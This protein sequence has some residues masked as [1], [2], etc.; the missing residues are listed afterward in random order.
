MEEYSTFGK[1][2]RDFMV[3]NDYIICLN[4]LSDS[5]TV[6]YEKDNRVSLVNEINIERPL[7]VG[8]W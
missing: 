7:C 3:Y 2:P 6:L 4:E 8:V 5:V 1:S